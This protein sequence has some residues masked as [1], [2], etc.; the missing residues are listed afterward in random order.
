MGT[1]IGRGFLAALDSSWMIRHWSLGG[2]P[3][4]VLAERENLYRLLPQTS[5][6]NLQ[7]NFSL[8]SVDPMTRY[9]NIN[10]LLITPA[11]SPVLSCVMSPVPCLILCDLTGPVLSCVMSPVPCLILCDVTGLLSYPGGVTGPLSYPV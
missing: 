5:P 9:Q 11:Q 1:G 10:R 6:E 7:K 3:L 4:E 8:F 2:A